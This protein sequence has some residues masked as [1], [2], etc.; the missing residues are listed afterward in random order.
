MRA[1]GEPVIA[2]YDILDELGR[3]GNGVVYLARQRSLNRLVAIKMITPERKLSASQVARILAEAELIARLQHPNIVGIHRVGLCEGQPYLVLEYVRGGSLAQ[4]VGKPWPAVAAASLVETLARTLA[5]VHDQGIVHRDLKPANVLLVRRGPPPP[6]PRTAEGAPV[7]A[8]SPASAEREE[9]VV[10]K[11][12]DF[13]LAKTLDEAE[14]TAGRALTEPGEL[15]GTP[16]YMAPEQVVGKSELIGATDQH[17]LG[18]IL[19]EL[20]TGRP[21]FSASNAFDMLTEVAFTI[22]E[23]PSRRVRGVSPDLDAVVMR[24]L[25]KEPRERYGSVLELAEDLHRVRHGFP[26]RSRT[27][28]TVERMRM[29]SRRQPVV[30]A[31]MLTVLLVLVGGLAAASLQWLRRERPRQAESARLEAENAL[32]RET[33]ER[34]K[35]RRARDEAADARDTAKSALV[36]EKAA[37]KEADLARGK[38]AKARRRIEQQQRRLRDQFTES[39]VILTRSLVALAEGE[40]GRNNFPRAEEYLDDCPPST[41]AWEWYYLARLCD[42]R[43]ATFAGP[44]ASI[45]SVAVSADGAWLAAAGRASKKGGLMGGA[46]LSDAGGKKP[47]R[48][49]TGANCVA[50]R[51]KGAWLAAANPEGGVL[52]YSLKDGSAVRKLG[53]VHYRRLVWAP[54]SETLAAL[55]DDA[56]HLWSITPQGRPRSDKP[57]EVDL[58]WLQK[59]TV[60]GAAFRPDGKVLA[61]AGKGQVQFWNVHQRKLIAVPAKPAPKR[62]A[63]STSSQEV[64]NFRIIHT[65]PSVLTAMAWPGDDLLVTGA[66]DGVIRLYNVK[67]ELEKGD[68]VRTA[69]CDPIG[70]RGVHAA[71]VEELSCS[72]VWKMPATDKAHPPFLASVAGDGTARV[73]DFRDGR[74]LA[75]LPGASSVAVFPNGDRVLTAQLDR[76]LTVWATRPTAPALPQTW[77][78]Q[79]VPALAFS[80]ATGELTTGESDIVYLNDPKITDKPKDRLALP[81]N[82]VHTLAYH[83]SG[84]LLAV[85]MGKKLDKEGKPRLAIFDVKTRRMTSLPGQLAGVLALAFSPNGKLLA[86]GGRYGSVRLWHGT[87]DGAA[88]QPLRLLTPHK[89]KATG[90]AFSPDSRTLATTGEDGMVLLHDTSDGQLIRKMRTR[91]AVESEEEGGSPVRG[92]GYGVAFSP[93]GK[94]LATPG[95]P[96][97]VLFNVASG[98]EEGNLVGHTG[99]VGSVVFSPDGQRLATGGADGTVR[100]WDTRRKVEVLSLGGHT[101]SVLALAFSSDGRFLASSAR[102]RTVLV[103]EAPR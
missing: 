45:V 100:L 78:A 89:G 71:P 86:S 39:Q 36:K 85:G 58:Q 13:G 15:L 99:D 46:W 29:W 74:E 63:K 49:L 18:I 31:L 34:D 56:V 88:W 87:G 60:R 55:R 10:P 84:R 82:N 83:P 79:I 94:Q 54:D 28:G 59:K 80:P 62:T 26:S 67:I 72:G 96:G 101:Q 33:I 48:H 66:T 50:F 65:G 16:L 4:R 95:Q 102:D 98:E 77:H 81:L 43:K 35:A 47:P 91:P 12:V 27:V 21:P 53:K 8:P 2:G 51:P 9:G 76:R 5:V 41:R 90:I 6:V 75:R 1:H 44:G 92:V 30:A 52:L 69:I 37:R 57:V 64:K 61:V 70:Q 22:P 7:A 25:A 73:L 103:H 17:A 93:D 24:C 38:E 14:P 32:A 19:H 3:G 97:V 20:L 23:P 11:I 42:M 40:R 68:V